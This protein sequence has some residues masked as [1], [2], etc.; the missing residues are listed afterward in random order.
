MGFCSESTGA[1]PAVDSAPAA[2]PGGSTAT[3]RAPPRQNSRGHAA[4]RGSPLWTPGTAPLRRD[5]RLIGRLARSLMRGALP[6]ALPR[7]FAQGYRSRLPFP[8]GTAGDGDDRQGYRGPAAAA[9]RASVNSPAQTENRTQLPSQSK[10]IDKLMRTSWVRSQEHK[11]V[12][13]RER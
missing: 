4:A 6:L 12:R 5:R 13:F 1:S 11:W 2:R 9:R 10:P 7:I 8:H 3:P